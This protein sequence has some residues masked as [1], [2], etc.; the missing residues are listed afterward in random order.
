MFFGLRRPSFADPMLGLWAALPRHVTAHQRVCRRPR[1][2]PADRPQPALPA[3]GHQWRRSWAPWRR[4]LYGPVLSLRVKSGLAGS[5]KSTKM[6]DRRGQASRSRAA[7]PDSIPLN[8]PSRVVHLRCRPC[9]PI[10][11]SKASR[12][13]RHRNVDGV[14]R[15]L[16]TH[17]RAA[18]GVP[19][20]FSYSRTVY[21]DALRSVAGTLPSSTIG[22]FPGP[23]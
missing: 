3:G 14:T 21:W 13:A 17:R 20:R 23:S 2:H 12:Q 18:P 9:L 7:T 22:C 11:A 19:S 10:R 8:V 4:R 1:R 6:S 15:T 16:R 5:I